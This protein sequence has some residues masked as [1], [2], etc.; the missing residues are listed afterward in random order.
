[1]SEVRHTDWINAVAVSSSCI[2]VMFTHHCHCITGQYSTDIQHSVVG[3]V[4]EDVD[5]GDNGHGDGDGQ[6]QV[7][8]NDKMLGLCQVDSR[9]LG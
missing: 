3:Q 8:E 1:M 9:G 2:P 6:R 4:G 5:D 7:P